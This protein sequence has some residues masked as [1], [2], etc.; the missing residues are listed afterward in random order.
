MNNQYIKKMITYMKKSYLTIEIPNNMSLKII[1]KA[2]SANLIDHIDDHII[3]I[4]YI[5]D[6]YIDNYYNNH[7]L[8]DIV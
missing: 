7:I 1:P 8:N 4:H 3:D 5:S 2:S 6:T